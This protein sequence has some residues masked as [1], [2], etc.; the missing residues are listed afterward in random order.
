MLHEWDDVI[1]RSEAEGKG[2]VEWQ[3]SGPGLPYSD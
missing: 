2:Q 3:R 1:G